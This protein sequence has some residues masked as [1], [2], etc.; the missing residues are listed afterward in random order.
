MP[1]H[2]HVSLWSISSH[3]VIFSILLLYLAAFQ[4]A[5][6]QLQGNHII[7]VK[8]LFQFKVPLIGSLITCMLIFILLVLSLHRK[9]TI[10]CK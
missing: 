10:D 5:E 6:N 8:K 4:I 1:Y 3:A 2:E 7:C 9:P